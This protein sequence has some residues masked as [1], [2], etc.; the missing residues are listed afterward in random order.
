MTE[1]EFN[2]QLQDLFLNV[3]G[4]AVHLTRDRDRG[5]DLAQHM[6]WDAVARDYVL[7]GINRAAKAQRLAQIA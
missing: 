1:K 3:V 2:R 6:S 5:Y 7:P 4:F